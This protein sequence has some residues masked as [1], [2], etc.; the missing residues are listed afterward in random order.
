MSLLRVAGACFWIVCG[1]LGGDCVRVRAQQH[2]D[3]LGKTLQL[4]RR[5]EQE[6]SCRRA[7]LGSLYRALCREGLVPPEAGS[8]QKLS[9]PAS[10]SAREADC[11]RE[12]VSGLGHTEAVQE[13]ERLRL[14]I[15]RFEAFRAE[16]EQAVQVRFA[17]ARR[18][19][20]GAGLA[21]AILFL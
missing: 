8:F 17:L 10:F 1:W 14:Y 2:L 3:D 15:L 16:A 9:P 7:E 18:L 6:I 13:C 19:G 5:L 20:L 12:C 11:F 4:L 21:T